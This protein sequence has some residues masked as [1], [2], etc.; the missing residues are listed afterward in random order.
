M[1]PALGWRAEVRAE[2][3][4]NVHGGVCAD[5]PGFGKTITSL[6]LIHSYLSSGEDIAGGLRT[7]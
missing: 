1:I 6:A 7:R 3:E 2:T 4:I 5:H